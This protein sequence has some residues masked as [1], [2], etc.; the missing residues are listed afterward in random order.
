[1]RKF[2]LSD[3]I[4]IRNEKGKYFLFDNVNGNIF[5]LNEL[6]YEILSLCDGVWDEE[7]ILK[8][9][10]GIFDVSSENIYN[11]FNFLINTLLEKKYIFI[12]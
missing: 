6:S 4:G 2:K 1:M 3:S 8:K 11:D 12:I 10:S 5:K 9:I 7:M